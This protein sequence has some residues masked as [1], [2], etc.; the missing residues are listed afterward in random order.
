MQR[1]RNSKCIF[2]GLTGLS[3]EHIWPEWMREYF[4]RADDSRYN[5]E[6][7]RARG[8]ERDYAPK[9]TERPGHVS[10]AKLRVV[11]R[12][13]NSGWMNQL[14]IAAKPIFTNILEKN[15]FAIGLE[16]QDVLAHWIAMKSIVVEHSQINEHIT[17]YHDRERLRSNALIPEFLSIFLGRYDGSDGT[18]FRKHSAVFSHTEAGPS[19]PLE[20]RTKNVQTVSMIIG[21]LFVFALTARTDFDLLKYFNSSQ[22][23]QI[24]P[25]GELSFAWPLAPLPQT[26]LVN[27]AHWLED[28][29]QHPRVKYGGEIPK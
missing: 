16:E 25:I 4:P 20:G 23:T 7:H 18:S 26:T 14:E 8:K 5:M 27:I 24:W 22:L 15:A 12:N 11:C 3:K 13:C 21:D 29:I 1:R 19:P 17:P 10:S 6:V 28:L 2:C 9:K